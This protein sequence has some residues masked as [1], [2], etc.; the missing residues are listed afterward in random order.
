MA[1]LCGDRF[2]DWWQ[3]FMEDRIRGW[4]TPPVDVELEDVPLVSVFRER[5]AEMLEGVGGGAGLDRVGGRGNE[6]AYSLSGRT[7]RRRDAGA[8]A[9]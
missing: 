7:Y 4:V 3:W 5:Q 9:R 8:C 1:G 2:G 6:T